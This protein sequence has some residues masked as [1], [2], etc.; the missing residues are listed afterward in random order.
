[1]ADGEELPAVSR[2]GRQ[3]TVLHLRGD[4]VV[5]TDVV[6]RPADFA[7]A[8]RLIAAG[9]AVDSRGLADPD[10]PLKTFIASRVAT[11]A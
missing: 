1:M 6:N 11:T 7:A 10:V 5:A 2:A 8:K 3:L 9:H 4:V